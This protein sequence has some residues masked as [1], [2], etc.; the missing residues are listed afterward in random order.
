ME[1]K[2]K[3]MK[4][5]LPKS[6]YLF[7]VEGTYYKRDGRTKT[8]ENFSGIQV[9]L[10]SK[11]E[12]LRKIRRVLIDPILRKKFKN[13]SRHQTCRIVDEKPLGESKQKAVVRDKLSHENIMIMNKDELT[14]FVLQENLPLVVATESSI[15]EARQK[16]SDAWDD[17]Q[18]MELKQKKAAEVRKKKQEEKDTLLQMNELDQPSQEFSDNI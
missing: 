7:T 3:Q 13:F 9:V 4:Q 17:K 12:A 8:L 6:G 5:N 16:A 1:N 2:G 11:E 15:L 14:N 18:L 10:P